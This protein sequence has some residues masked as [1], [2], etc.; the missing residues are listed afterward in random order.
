MTIQFECHNCGKQLSTSDDKAGKVGKCPDCGEPVS[1]PRPQ[2]PVEEENPY[3]FL[4][5]P[6][7]AATAARELP[8]QTCPMC[9]AENSATASD[10]I[11]CGE[12]L[13]QP[14]RTRNSDAHF[15]TGHKIEVGLILST[16]WDRFSAQMGMSIAGLIIGY[17]SS[18]GL[19]YVLM[20]GILIS[21]ALAQA[22]IA[23][24]V[25]AGIF[26]YLASLVAQVWLGLG[27]CQFSLSVGRGEEPQ[28]T[29]IFTAGR[30]I[31]RGVLCGLLLGLI[32]MGAIFGLFF[33]SGAAGAVGG[34]V[35]LGVMILISVLAVIW[36]MMSF[37]WTGFVLV[38]T[39]AGGVSSVFL[40]RELMPGNYLSVLLLHILCQMIFV[41]GFLALGV[42]LII[43]FPFVMVI[44]AVT[45][46]HLSGGGPAQLSRHD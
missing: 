7:P 16:A 40:S 3:A 12:T 17:F 41:A 35:V 22:S 14:E 42:G 46:D 45:Y 34:E 9:G 19:S 4:D 27:M 29:D 8:T 33:V 20:F 23:L 37:M 28:L 39:D 25:L 1:V 11:Q 15:S 32:F 13:R 10:C 18:A 26:F 36:L 24:A 30:F 44:L 21:F 2:V 38:D 5:Q 43:A 6:A 31:G